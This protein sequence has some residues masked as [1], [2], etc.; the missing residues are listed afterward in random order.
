MSP[1]APWLA[2]PILALGATG[3]AIA[4]R[5]GGAPQA[6]GSRLVLREDFGGTRLDARR[7]RRCHWW[8]R[9]G[10]TIASNGE[11]EWYVPGQVRVHGGALRLVAQRG[12]VR[13]SDGRVY[14]YR[15]GMISSGPGPGSSAPRFAFRYGRA[16]IRARVPRGRG[17]WSAFWLLP[18]N[19]R[20]K[21]EI[22]VMEIRGGHPDTVE[23]H[24]HWRGS[25]GATRQRGR[26]WRQAGLRRGWHTF[27][28]DWRP[29]RLT[30]LVDGRVRWMVRGR[31]VPRT[32]MYLVADLAVGGEWAGSPD[33]STR[34]P[35]A[36]VIDS[37]R[38]W[39]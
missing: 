32:R 26:S 39:R 17:L 38:V 28:I 4:A 29:G 16:Q 33:D 12:P 11:L 8:A 24:V 25:G 2:L 31:A 27:A 9:G 18:A 15:S 6:Q 23:F 30:W 10:C 36:L 20:S 21:P 22:D 13:G 14:P 34:F 7:W 19:R 3:A 5:A 1:P 35:S 37:V